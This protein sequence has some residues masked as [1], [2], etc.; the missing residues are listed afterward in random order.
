MTIPGSGAVDLA[1]SLG[2]GALAV[3]GG[4]AKGAQWRD[5]K[6]GSMSIAMMISGIATALVMATVVR[7]AGVHYGVEPWVQVAGSGVLCYVGPDPILRAIAGMALKRFGVS[8]NGGQ[9]DA[10]KH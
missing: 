9:D 2:V 5:P 1:T 3:V 6:T 4:V 8:D 7:A 10:H